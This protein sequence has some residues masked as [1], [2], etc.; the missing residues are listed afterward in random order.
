MLME[1]TSRTSWRTLHHPL[2]PRPSQLIFLAF[3]F[4]LVLG[5]ADQLFFLIFIFHSV[6]FSFA[7]ADGCKCE[8]CNWISSP[9]TDKRLLLCWGYFELCAGSSVY[10]CVCGELMRERGDYT[11]LQHWARTSTHCLCLYMCLSVTYGFCTG[12]C[13]Y[14]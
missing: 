6:Y 9:D 2:S 5:E 14:C 1:V 12:S 3:I 4:P 13:K 7:L 10:V 8:L 11:H